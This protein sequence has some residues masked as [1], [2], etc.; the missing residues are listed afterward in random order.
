MVYGHNPAS[1]D[2]STLVSYTLRP[3]SATTISERPSS[4]IFAPSGTIIFP[5][6]V[7]W[8]IR[9][10]SISL[11]SLVPIS[12]PVESESTVVVPKTL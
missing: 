9:V 12:T 10:K 8:S 5:L 11:A 2:I 1:F 4:G 3:F 6:M 7:F